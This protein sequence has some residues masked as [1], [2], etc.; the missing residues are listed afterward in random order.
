MKWLKHFF[1]RFV[2]GLSTIGAQSHSPLSENS[3]SVSSAKSSLPQPIVSKPKPQSESKASEWIA[4]ERSEKNI[5]TLEPVTA[6]LA[7][8]H[9]RRLQAEGLNFKITSA[10]R[11]FAEQHALYAKGRATKGPKVTNAR[12]GHS[13]H[14]FGVA[15]D[16]TLFSGKNP[17]WDSPK[18]ARAGEIGEEI[19]LEWGGRW[20]RFVDRPH[21]QRRMA[22]TLAEARAKWPSGVAV[23]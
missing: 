17:V 15:Y 21:F 8:E 11:T 13:W 7:R 14:N 12:A 6:R 18:Y 23:A 9:L 20:K 19:G 5:A 4:D 1:V 10:R 2:D 22:L 16:L 3:P